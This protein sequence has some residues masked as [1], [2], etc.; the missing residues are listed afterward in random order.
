MTTLFFLQK[1][2]LTNL[3][4]LKLV[5][6]IV[7]NNIIFHSQHLRDALSHPWLDHIQLD[8]VDVDLRTKLLP[9]FWELSE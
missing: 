8:L 3:L 5:E 6:D 1:N 7:H 9:K 4:R 2:L